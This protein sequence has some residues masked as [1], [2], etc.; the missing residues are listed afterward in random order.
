[1]DCRS[2]WNAPADPSAHTSSAV[3][4]AKSSAVGQYLGSD[5]QVLM[6]SPWESKIESISVRKTR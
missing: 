5:A 6:G 3:I 2:R 1:M 4:V